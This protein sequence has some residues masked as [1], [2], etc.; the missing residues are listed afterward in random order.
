MK[1]EL[2][3]ITGDNRRPGMPADHKYLVRYHQHPTFGWLCCRT[4]LSEA[5]AK[6]FQRIKELEAI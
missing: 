3:L 1:T 5:A 2:E 6:E 4:F